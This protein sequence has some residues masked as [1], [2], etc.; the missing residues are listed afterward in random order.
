MDSKITHKEILISVLLILSYTFTGINII[1]NNGNLALI[2]LCL[3]AVFVLLIVYLIIADSEVEIGR[4]KRRIESGKTEINNKPSIEKIG[5]KKK[6]EPEKTRSA[7]GNAYIQSR[8]S[9]YDNIDFEITDDGIN[10]SFVKNYQET[11]QNERSHVTIATAKKKAMEAAKQTEQIAR[12]AKE[13]AIQSGNMANTLGNKTVKSG[14]SDRTSASKDAKRRSRQVQRV[15]TKE[16]THVNPQS[17]VTQ[18]T[19]SQSADTQ[20]ENTQSTKLQ[21]KVS[22]P[23]NVSEVKAAPAAMVE[24]ENIQN[25]VVPEETVKTARKPRKNRT[26]QK[27]VPDFKTEFNPEFEK[28]YATDGLEGDLGDGIV[29]EEGVGNMRVYKRGEKIEYHDED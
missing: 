5:K 17:T 25:T 7:S 3:S 26:K 24:S 11:K 9:D 4:L 18:S 15:K 21:T 13:N 29:G 12:V 8:L 2:C 22:Q 19:V 28:N 27:F 6:G 1:N 23:E 10:T 20:S 16:S 14:S